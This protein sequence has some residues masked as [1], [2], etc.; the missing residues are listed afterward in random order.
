M[1]DTRHPIPKQFDNVYGEIARAVGVDPEAAIPEPP[2]TAAEMAIAAK[3]ER[4]RKAKC[5]TQRPAR[6]RNRP[7]RSFLFQ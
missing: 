1:I 7:L 5:R 4:E 6:K 3:H 2:L